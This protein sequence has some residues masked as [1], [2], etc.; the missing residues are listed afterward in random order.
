M[1]TVFKYDTPIIIKQ[2]GEYE[3]LKVFMSKIYHPY[4]V[5]EKID[6]LNAQNDT[7]VEDTNDVSYG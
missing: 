4:V 6:E 2:S 1:L 7:S 5:Q 3:Q